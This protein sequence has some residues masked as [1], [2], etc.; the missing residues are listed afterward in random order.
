MEEGSKAAAFF[1]A[2]C[3]PEQ[4]AHVRV[5]ENALHVPCRPLSITGRNTDEKN[6][7]EQGLDFEEFLYSL[8]IK[9]LS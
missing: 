2:L 8:V 3:F 5:K 6:C 4:S 7:R 9:G 1:P